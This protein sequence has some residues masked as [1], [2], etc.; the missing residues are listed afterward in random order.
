MLQDK[1]FFEPGTDVMKGPR[2][3]IIGLLITMILFFVAFVLWAFFAKLDVTVA[4]MGKA[5]PSAQLQVV[6]NL[7]GGIVESILVSEG[8]RVTKG[9]VLLTIDQTSFAASL[10]EQESEYRGL[11]A[12]LVRLKA[13]AKN[14]TTLTFPEWLK[15]YPDLLAREE[16]LFQRRLED[17][18]SKKQVLEDQL[19]QK[20]LAYKELETKIVYQKRS[21][22]IATK[23][24]AANKPLLETGSISE[25][26]LLALKGELNGLEGD[27]NIQKVS[28]DRV[29]AEIKEINSRIENQQAT[30]RSES[31]KEYN[32]VMIRVESLEAGIKD[33][34]YKVARRIVKSPVNGEVNRILVNTIGGVIKPGD[35]L[36]EIVPVE[37]KLLLEL[38]VYPK[39]IGFIA[40]NQKA[41]IRFSAYDSAVFG[42]LDGKVTKIGA[43]TLSD[44][45]G[46]TFYQ[47]V[48]T[49][50]K[51]YLG[52]K[53]KPM[54]LIPGMEATV[55]ITTGK[56]T[57]M[58]YI[59]K[60]IVRLRDRAIRER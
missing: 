57:V 32:E 23:K 7:E 54:L 22:D 16:L 38:I 40:P 46:R 45:E 60:P 14:L 43:D 4:A 18:Q 56:R 5:V 1:T 29:M 8:D 53:E 35:D 39:D 9:Q 2:Q 27:L 15:D 13:E 47:V 25:L 55:Q 17:W 11:Q 33:G 50:E 26:E 31:L 52:S 6:Q 3:V 51:N 42:A 49:A 58:D 28:K 37:D 34:K 21:V 24:L 12:R 36:V 30:I 19:N 44:K 41:A 10:K 48:V 59:M 20:K